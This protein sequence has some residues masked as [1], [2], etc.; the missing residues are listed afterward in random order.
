MTSGPQAQDEQ[1]CL[2]QRGYCSRNCAVR[3][4]KSLYNPVKSS[5]KRAEIQGSS[6]KS[7]AATRNQ[8]QAS[9]VPV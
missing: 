1:E 4:A 3:P 9:T 2:D 5:A 7:D 6:P 8:R